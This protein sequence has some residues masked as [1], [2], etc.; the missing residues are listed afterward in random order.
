MSSR[1]NLLVIC[2]GFPPYYGGAEHVAYYL[3]VE[4]A[5]SSWAHVHVLTSDIGGRLDAC[6][7]M[8]GMTIH[9][10]PTRKKEWTRHTVIELVSFYRAAMQHLPMLMEK[11]CPDYILAHFGVPAGWVAQRINAID[12]T[13]YSVVLHGSDV[14]DYQPRRF[15]LVY[16]LLRRLVRSIWQRADHVITVSDELRSLALKTW[17]AGDI[18]VV[19]NGVDADFF[20]PPAPDCVTPSQRCR[21][22][23][24]A[25]LIERKGIQYLITAMGRLKEACC[26]D[27]Y[28]TGPYQS[29]LEAHVRDAGLNDTIRFHGVV[30]RNDLLAALQAADLFVLP[31][32]QEG[33]P[34]ALLEAMACGLGIVSTDVGGIPEVLV[35]EENALL[36]PPGDA[37]SLAEALTRAVQDPALRTR[38]G[39]AS[40]Q[41]AEQH[42]WR[43]VWRRYECLIDGS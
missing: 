13:P 3:G 27:I 12:R 43:Q 15:R 23:C 30:D 6:E 35:H 37:S 2:H 31:S 26:L 34:L 20:R 8:D 21:L 29:V 16:P 41:T 11:T 18:S 33:L 7:Q 10:V 25:Q 17:P 36:V 28:G 4:A 19:R 38:L 32:L 1:G 9:R 22:I 42:T 5:R 39:L 40:C 14:P 24:T